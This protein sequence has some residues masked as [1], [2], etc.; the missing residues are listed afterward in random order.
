MYEENGF[1]RNKNNKSEA[2][3]AMDIKDINKALSKDKVSDE[4]EGDACV[5]CGSNQ[6]LWKKKY[7]K[8]CRCFYR[9]VWNKS[10]KCINRENNCTITVITRTNC[11]S[12]RLNSCES[13]GMEKPSAP[14]VNNPLSIWQQKNMEEPIQLPSEMTKSTT[15]RPIKYQIPILPKPE[16]LQFTS[17]EEKPKKKKKRRKREEMEIRVSDKANLLP[18]T[19]CSAVEVAH[20]NYGV[21]CCKSCKIFFLRSVGKKNIY[22]CVDGRN[23]CTVTKHNRT[24]CKR[25]RYERC[26]SAGFPMEM[27][28]LY[29]KTKRASIYNKNK[30]NKDIKENGDTHKDYQQSSE[31][32]FQNNNIV[33]ILQHSKPSMK[34]VYPIKLSDDEIV[35]NQIHEVKKEKSVEVH[36]PKFLFETIPRVKQEHENVERLG[37]ETKNYSFPIEDIYN[38]VKEDSMVENSVNIQLKQRTTQTQVVT[39][40][41]YPIPILPKPPL[42]QDIK[43]DN[44]NFSSVKLQLPVR[45]DLGIIKSDAANSKK[46]ALELEN[47]KTVYTNDI[48]PSIVKPEDN[49]IVVD[50]GTKEVEPSYSSIF[51]YDSLAGSGYILQ[52]LL[53]NSI[54]SGDQNVLVYKPQ[55]DLIGRISGKKKFSIRKTEKDPLDT[56]SHQVLCKVCQAEAPGQVFYGGM[57]CYS[58]RIFFRRAAVTGAMFHCCAADGGCEVSKDTRI[59]CKQ[60]R[61]MRCLAAGMKPELVDRKVLRKD[62]FDKI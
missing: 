23:S 44:A 32:G 37:I 41:K 25:C 34:L 54:D 15:I 47:A 5:I 42:H 60:C 38:T 46:Y 50:S 62:C 2:I 26:L 56:T 40:T 20:K 17:H 7:C 36:E 8:S 18:C 24:N 53:I 21:E 49:D 4:P 55:E 3:E 43:T 51:V 58:C 35:T 29:T 6:D 59:K 48:F 12:C 39:S 57:C 22:K 61:Y 31:T 28:D 19:I 27:K 9:R 14:I 45:T 33:D 11:K 52:N 13:S 30:S 16:Q 10:F 1:V